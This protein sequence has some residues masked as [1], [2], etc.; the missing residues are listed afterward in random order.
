MKKSILFII[1]VALSSCATSPFNR[2]N[3]TEIVYGIDFSPF[4]QKG[5]LITPEKYA[6]SY[7]S[8]GLINYEAFPGAN[9]KEVEKSIENYYGSKKPVIF[10]ENKWVVDSISLQ[11]VLTKVYNICVEMGADALVNFDYE[12]IP[13]S[14]G[15]VPRAIDNPLTIYGIHISG[16]A[17]KRKEN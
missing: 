7:E 12:I 6:G 8:I 5:F 1:V 13:T 16:Y 14:Y 17:I 15:S 9:Y 11:D 3:P 2:I 10:K 4:T